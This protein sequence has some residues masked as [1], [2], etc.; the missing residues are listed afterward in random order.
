VRALLARRL[1][2]AVVVIAVV[3]TVTF[4]LIHL[5]PGDPIA[6]GLAD[7][8]ISEATRQYWRHFYGFDQP[9]GIQYVKY[10]TGVLQGHLGYSLQ[11]NEPVSTVV[12]RA[13]PNTLMLAGSGIV[14]SFGLGVII[15]LI[16]VARRGSLTDRALGV[17]SL[18]LYCTP[19]FWLAEVA[20]LAFAYWIPI[21]PAGGIVD[22]VI[23]PYLTAW[24]AFVDRL[25]HLILPAVT[26]AAL[27]AALVARFQRA[28][29]LDVAGDDYLRTARAKG[30]PEWAVIVRHALRNAALPV[31]SLLGLS[32]PGFLTGTVFVEKIFAW[33]GLGSLAVNAVAARDYPVVIACTLIASVAVA[34]GSLIAD[35]LYLIADPRLR[36]GSMVRP[37]AA[38]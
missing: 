11:F 10:V 4:F 26:L 30:V 16:Q 37:A 15:A 36:H 6:G 19:D 23:H 14:L 21:F 34:L 27:A 20:L 35:V 24:P 1:L 9:L 13:L 8:R 17:V 5:A 3:T 25:R 31:I 2:Q 7:L 38:A 29:L 32:L 18:T 22:P 33:P 12:A 28:A